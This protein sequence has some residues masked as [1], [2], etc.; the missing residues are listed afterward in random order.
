MVAIPLNTRPMDFQPKEERPRSMIMTM[1]IGCTITHPVTGEIV[2][3]CQGFGNPL[4]LVLR[5]PLG[6]GTIDLRPLVQEAA[7]HLFNTPGASNDQA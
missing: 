4:L 5:G 7:L 1:D 6:E 2:D 3:V